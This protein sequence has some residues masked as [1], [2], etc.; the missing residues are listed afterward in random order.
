MT[1]R[2]IL[3]VVFLLSALSLSLFSVGRVHR[4]I[5][6]VLYE[7]D[8]NEDIYSCA[9]NVLGMRQS[10][11]RVFSLFL[12]HTDADM[13]DRLH[14]ELSFAL[15]KRN[16]EKITLLLSEIY[17]FLSV[18]GEGEKVKSENIF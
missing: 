2:L 4:E 12:K 9:R 6:A 16:D 13:I 5:N 14:I 7:I 18:T 15:E 11:E 10:N 1:K 3:S 8:T 17:A